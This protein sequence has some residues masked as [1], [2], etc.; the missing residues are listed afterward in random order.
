M[1]ALEV[2]IIY[3]GSAY[4]GGKNIRPRRRLLAAGGITAAWL[5]SAVALPAIQIRCRGLKGFC[6]AGFGIC[7]APGES[8]PDVRQAAIMWQ[9]RKPAVKTAYPLS[10]KGSFT[11]NYNGGG[12]Y[13][14]NDQSFSEYLLAIMNAPDTE[15]PDLCRMPQTGPASGPDPLQKGPDTQFIQQIRKLTDEMPGGFFIYRAD[16]QEEIIYANHALIRMFGCETIK[17]FR[18]L[19]GNSFQGVVH[20]DDLDQVE[21]SI[22][23]QIAHSQYDLDYVEYRII[24]KDG[25]IR[26]IEDYG[27]FLQI[28]GVGDFFY[29][30]SRDATE[31]KE[32]MLRERDSILSEKKLAEEKLQNQINAFNKELMAINQEQLQRL[33][34]IEGLSVD[35]EAIFYAN[36][37]LNQIKAYRVNSWL[38][39]LLGQ[40]G[41]TYD[42]TGYNARYIQ[43]LVCPEDR[44]RVATA[45]C[46]GYIRKRLPQSQTFH[47]NYRAVKDKKTEY[48]Q[49]RVA[50]VGDPTHISQIIIGYRNIDDDI[51]HEMERQKVLESALKQAK[52]AN[53]AKN[54]FLA[55]MSHDIRTPLNAIL[56]FTS[57]AQNHIDDPEKIK[58]CLEQIS[59]SG[60]FL[61]TLVNNVLEL[62][63]AEAG[64]IQI[65]EAPCNLLELAQEIQT[66]VLPQIK[67]KGMVFD[68]KFEGVEHPNVYG[69]PHKLQQI[70]LY[71]IDNAIKYTSPGGLVRAIF[72]ESKKPSGDYASFQIIVEDNGIGISAEFLNHIFEPFE[73]QKN[74][75]LSNVQGIGLGLTITKSIVDL[76]GGT[77]QVQSTVGQGSRF[78]V[79]LSLRMQEQAEPHTGRALWLPGNLSKQPKILL[80]EDNE[81]NLEIEQELLEDAGFEVEI[82]E[83]GRIAVEKVMQS[84]PGEYTLILMDIQMPVMDGHLAAQTIRNLD[85]PRLA[86]IPIIAL[87]ANAFDEDKKK[88]LESGMNAHMAKPMDLSQLLELM[89][90]IIP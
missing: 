63:R 46:P 86:N 40:D 62:S 60:Q 17:E 23:E 55:N 78:T 12:V 30:F 90:E 87:S 71:L 15:S 76:I 20:P 89:K 45:S 43:S 34:V 10:A 49:L 51:R 73:R 81:L 83:N 24:R 35:Y 82:A 66:F 16:G 58:N 61:L 53:I 3:I 31:K 32:R 36:L 69:D 22:W 8:V 84:K 80:V 13:M 65:R 6:H 18:E 59:S 48:R 2:Y 41:Q 57:L 19:T 4:P 26:W 44:E 37:D 77:I 25:T 79:S 42:F 7:N 88:S 75:T 74:T 21:K 56:G 39:E 38:E 64:N 54:T 68:L 5:T 29:V 72:R 9:N 47:V 28:D 52:L 14:T 50:N 11:I 27:H 70:L 67:K 33:E 1:I 85:D